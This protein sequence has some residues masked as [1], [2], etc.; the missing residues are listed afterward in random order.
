[1]ILGEAMK[2]LVTLK[3]DYSIKLYSQMTKDKAPK[4]IYLPMDEKA[5][6]K[7]DFLIKKEQRITNQGISPVSGRLIGSK[8]C[9]TVTKKNIKC[10]VILND[11]KETYQK[12]RAALKNITS[13]SLEK[14]ITELKQHNCISL[15]EKLKHSKKGCTLIL[16]GMDDEPY[17]ANEIFL[18]KEYYF[19]IL[20]TFDALRE[21]LNASSTK[22][23]MKCNDRENIEN[24]ENQMGT[25]LEMELLV[26]PDYYLIAEEQFLLP[27]LNLEDNY[28]ILKPSEIKTMVTVVQK[29]HYPTEV[30]ITISGNGI[31]NPQIIETKIGA[32]VKDLI[33]QYIKIKKNIDVIYCINGLLVG[34]EM[35]ISN[36]IV[37]NDLQSIMIMKKEI[38]ESKECIRC[39]K[40][41]SICPMN[42]NPK[43]GFDTNKQKYFSNCIHCGLCSYIC[44]SKI[45]FK[46]IISGEKNE[47]KVHEIPF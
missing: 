15:S 36:L 43:K 14:I 34:E 27:Y 47:T 25:Y 3:K 32:S 4:Y 10:F 28:L 21:K 30:V 31:E 7:S 11:Y 46:K 26:L 20:E 41:V 45:D 23:V 40:C 8:Y 39:G 16:N 13:V 18:S 42:C 19:E 33:Q 2:K 35:D 12:R 38:L 24:F 22:V 44:P 6:I 37:T 9:D 1:M 29:K 17:V 5:K